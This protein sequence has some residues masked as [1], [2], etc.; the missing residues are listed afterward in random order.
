MS[1]EQLSLKREQYYFDYGMVI[2]EK[3]R[4]RY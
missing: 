1:S 3:K 4:Q 2:W